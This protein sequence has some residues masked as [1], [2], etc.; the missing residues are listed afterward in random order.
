MPVPV[1]PFFNIEGAIPLC[2]VGDAKFDEEDNVDGGTCFE[3]ARVFTSTGLVA[4][5][6]CKKGED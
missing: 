2:K 4:M 1:L 6:L 5:K 3:P